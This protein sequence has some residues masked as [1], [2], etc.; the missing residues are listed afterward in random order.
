[1]AQ[2]GVGRV[3]TRRVKVPFAAPPAA[4]GTTRPTPIQPRTIP[5]WHLL[6]PFALTPTQ[7][8]SSAGCPILRSC[9][10][11]PAV[12]DKDMTAAK[13]AWRGIYP[14]SSST[15]SASGSSWTAPTQESLG[16]AGLFLFR[17]RAASSS[18]FVCG[19]ER[20]ARATPRSGRAWIAHF[21]HA[22]RSHAPRHHASRHH[23]SQQVWP[24]CGSAPFGWKCF[25]DIHQCL[26][27]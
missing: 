20:W 10:S 6:R 8:R 17:W 25:Y 12:P 18:A 19:G 26:L 22:F 24:G 23:R 7:T 15:G 1:V 3:S 9:D 2:F 21:Q 14:T 11:F 5:R 16:D 4:R 13:A 27:A